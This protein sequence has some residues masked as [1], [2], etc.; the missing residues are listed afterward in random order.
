MRAFSQ[1]GVDYISKPFNTEEVL[2]RVK[3][4][5]T[6]SSQQKVLTLQYEELKD[7]N[8]VISKQA[9]QLKILAAKDFLTG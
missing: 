1:G 9:E 6:L 8:V 5:L 4:H 2:A 7:K 3:T